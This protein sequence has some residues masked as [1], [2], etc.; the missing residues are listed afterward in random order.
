MAEVKYFLWLI[1]AE[2]RERERVVSFAGECPLDIQET[3]ERQEFTPF[4]KLV[5]E[6]RKDERKD[7]RE[8]E[9][10]KEERKKKIAPGS[11]PST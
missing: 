2:E 10:K 6:E 1:K 8:D 11:I 4:L 9:R 5:N 3:R 7:E